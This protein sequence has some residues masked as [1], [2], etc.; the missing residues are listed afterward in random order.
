MNTIL[1]MTFADMWWIFLTGM[2]LFL[3]L[4][5]CNILGVFSR[6]PQESK[7]AEELDRKIQ[8]TR[9]AAKEGKRPDFSE[10]KKRSNSKE[11]FFILMLIFAFM[12]FIFMIL[13]GISVIFKIAE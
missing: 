8:L 11:Y 1:A 4:S 10:F 6:R 2:I 9:A 13:T 12:T 3:C 7:I 5:L